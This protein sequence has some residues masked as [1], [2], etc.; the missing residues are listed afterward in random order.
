M[1][2]ERYAAIVRDPAARHERYAEMTSS[3]FDAFTDLY[4]ELWSDSLNLTWFTGQKSLAEAQKDHERKVGDLLGV[5]PGMRVL[6]VGCGIGNP[7]LE[8]SA[9]TGA[10][11]TGVTIS[12]RQVEVAATKIAEAG[13]ADRVE[14]VLGDA[15]ELPFPDNSFDA[16]YAIQAIGHMPD[17]PRVYRE[18]S[19][20][21]RDDTVLVCSDGF[22][23]SRTD[24]VDHGEAMEVLFQTFAVPSVTTIHEC[25]EELRA[26]G[27]GMEYLT[28]YSDHGDMTPNWAIGEQI[29]AKLM[30]GDGPSEL[31]FLFGASM[32]A[33][34]K[35]AESGALELYLWAA[36]KLPGRS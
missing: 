13:A 2:F 19:R 17:K 9:H 26:A 8:I 27:L 32:D 24:L 16:A 1:D 21:L 12:P 5:T 18:I 20:V 11:V 29:A 35:A 22:L 10:H 25:Q 23:R 14:V 36:R 7:A 34:G 30:G 28:R 33:L 6:D 15:M 31:S 4:R 3:Y